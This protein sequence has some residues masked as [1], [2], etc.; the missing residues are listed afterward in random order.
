MAPSVTLPAIGHIIAGKYVLQSLIGQGGMGSVFKAEH[1][2]TRRPVAIKVMLADPT[3]QEAINRF[4]REAEAAG[5]LQGESEN[6]VE[7]IDVDRENGYAYMVLE[8]LSGDDLGKVLETTKAPLP[9]IEAVRYV[10]EALEGLGRA[11]AR[12]IV[13]RDLK[14]SN[15]FRHK[16]PG[17]QGDII[18]ILDFGISKLAPNVLSERPEALTSTKAM[19]GSPLYMSPEQLKSS[20]TVDQRADIWAIGVILYELLTN[21]LPFYGDTLGELFAAILEAQPTAPSARNP[22]LPPQLDVVIL[23]CLRLRPEDRYQSCDELRLDLVRFSTPQQGNTVLASTAFMPGAPGSTTVQGG[24]MTGPG[25]PIVTPPGG[26]PQ[27]PLPYAPPVPPGAA[28]TGSGVHPPVVKPNAPM[29]STPQPGWGNTTG[30]SSLPKSNAGPILGAVAGG[31]LVLG[32]VGVGL[33]FYAHNRRATAAA[34]DPVAGE[35]TASSASASLAT[36]STPPSPPPPPPSVITPAATDTAAAQTAASSASAAAAVPK[37]PGGGGLH[38]RPPTVPV[39]PAE[40]PRVAET[41]AP[42]RP[43]T[44]P[45]K[46][47]PVNTV[48]TSR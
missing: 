46:P 5:Q 3:N 33:V 27:G 13:H 12:G 38:G 26:G 39:K 43:V 35:A 7:V 19:L 48:E 42:Q 10:L 31:V 47:P 6:I 41:P 9:M 8:L 23:K 15:L 25:V 1:R 11:H 14:P 37:P 24:H 21:S 30:G 40:P 45:A 2:A 34:G 17:N 44:P 18:K 29:G 4:Q 28:I 32:I 36:P 22:R 20:K 16:R